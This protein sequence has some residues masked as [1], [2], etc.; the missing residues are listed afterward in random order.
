MQIAVMYLRN[1]FFLVLFVLALSGCFGDDDNEVPQDWVRID[2][3]AADLTTTDA[4]IIVEGN[5]ALGN[6]NPPDAIY[7]Y[8]S[9][10]AS[11]VFPQQNI[12]ILACIAAF[13]D[14]IPLYT[15]TNIITV[16]LNNA[17]DTVTVI[18]EP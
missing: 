10:G 16:Q 15:G 14:N 5:A 12:C 2:V 18:R 4:Y 6:G 11:G 1:T 9:M 3:P 8:N 7:W 17:T 13:R